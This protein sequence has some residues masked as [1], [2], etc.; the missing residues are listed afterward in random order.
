MTYEDIIS[1]FRQDANPVGEMEAAMIRDRGRDFLETLD[2]EGD[3]E[4]WPELAFIG[5]L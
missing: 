4:T 5:A 1:I 3:D 2:R